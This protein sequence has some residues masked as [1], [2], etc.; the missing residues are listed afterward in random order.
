VLILFLI[1]VLYQLR[2]G[3]NLIDILK[4]RRTHADEQQD[5]RLLDPEEPSSFGSAGF[6]FRSQRFSIRSSRY[7]M[8][9]HDKKSRRA[10]QASPSP[11]QQ[12]SETYFLAPS[13]AARPALGRRSRQAAPA[14]PS[15]TDLDKL[16]SLSTISR[17]EMAHMGDRSPAS[18]SN[19]TAA[20]HGVAEEVALDRVESKCL[21]VTARPMKESVSSVADTRSRDYAP[22]ISTTHTAMDVIDENKASLVYELPTTPSTPTSPDMSR[23][24]TSVIRDTVRRLTRSD[25]QADIEKAGL[26]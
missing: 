22:S 4:L 25:L 10:S 5:L 7:T 24:R 8:S 13:S 1:F 12:Y 19:V 14:P 6:I 2:K 17:P 26:R 16:P 3:R 11:Y 9:L 15:Q 23:P 18:G 21:T 20:T